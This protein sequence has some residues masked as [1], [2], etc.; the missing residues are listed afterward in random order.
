MRGDWYIANSPRDGRGL[1][2]AGRQ[3]FGPA[4][5]AEAGRS[6]GGVSP[7]SRQAA[8]CPSSSRLSSGHE[9]TETGRTPC[10]PAIHLFLAGP[11]GRRAG[12][13]NVDGRRRLADV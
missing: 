3:K 4:I 11:P 9:Q 13:T 2:K 8:L 6:A 5:L 1:T 12:A 10:L 7:K